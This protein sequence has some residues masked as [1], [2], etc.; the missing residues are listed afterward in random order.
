MHGTQDFIVINKKDTVA[1]AVG[2]LKKGET[3]EIAGKEIQI[4][5]DISVPHKIALKNIKKGE[6]IRRYGYPIGFA[7][8][9]IEIG[10]HVHIHNM[11]SALTD[12]LAYEYL[13]QRA[14]AVRPLVTRELTFNGYHR[15]DGDVGIRNYIFIIPTVFCVNG[16]INKLATLAEKEMPVSDN[17][18]GFIP[19]GH[20]CGCGE[21]GQNLAYTRSILAGISKN[22]N[23][24]GVLFVGLGCEIN[25]IESFK[26]GLGDYDPERVKFIAYQDV[27]DEIEASLELL[28]ELHAHAL[29]YQRQRAPISKLIIGSN[30]GGSDGFSGLTANPLVGEITDILTAQGGTSVITEVPEMFGAE[31]ILMDRATDENVFNDI[32]KLIDN[33]KAYYKKYGIE[34]SKNPTPGNYQGG[35]STL[36]EKSLGCI[37]KGGKSK[38]TGVI[39]YGERLKKPGLNLYEAPGHDLVGIS[40]QVAAGCTLIIFTTGRGTPGGFAA[41]VL[42]VTTNSDIFSRKQNWNDFDAGRLL[43]G[44]GIQ[45][46]TEDFLDLILKVADGKVRTR[47]EVN[48]FFEMGIW[49]DG[50]TT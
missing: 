13:P 39:R 28:R 38:V 37:E 42:R 3:I 5:D 29:T 21:T 19:F 32:V 46:L 50:I 36:E 24:A 14:P 2:A 31:Q 15:P 30:C 47:T 41:P 35:L 25:D 16:P 33:G 17:F 10:D 11:K 34:V 4:Q 27:E 12:A 20:E 48:Q 7:S 43:E 9:D 23:A 44:T 18:D 40:G 26:P 1:V 6:V 22:P 45:K 8:K 49:R